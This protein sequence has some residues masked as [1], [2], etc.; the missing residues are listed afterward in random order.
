MHRSLL[1]F[2]LVTTAVLF[3]CPK[4]SPSG[5]A[6]DGSH[7]PDGMV[8]PGSAPGDDGGVTP[9]VRQGCLSDADC[10]DGGGVCEGQGCGPDQP[11][12][13]APADRICTR[14]SQAYCGCDGQ[15]FRASGG[16]PGQRYASRGECAAASDGAGTGAVADGSPCRTGSDCQSGV[17]EGEGC[18][19]DQ[20]GECK[21][22]TRACTRDFRAYCGCD[23][24]VFRG[25]GSC[26]GQRYARRGEC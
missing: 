3:A 25:S 7:P 23:G 18:G 12:T 2:I 11:G 9:S 6:D 19:D 15:T 20:L 8:D 17:C 10:H 24:Q 1:G 14:D 4:P 21:P 22:A 16:C 5:G 26:P 13:C